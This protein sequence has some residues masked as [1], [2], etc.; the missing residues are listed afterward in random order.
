MLVDKS[1][2][3]ELIIFILI[4]CTGYFYG[5][6]IVLLFHNMLFK[7]TVPCPGRNMPYKGHNKKKKEMCYIQTFFHMDEIWYLK[8]Y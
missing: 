8:S 7:E 1:V 4:Q 3:I 2:L 6:V 5:Y